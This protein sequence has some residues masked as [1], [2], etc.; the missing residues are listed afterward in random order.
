MGRT[1]KLISRIVNA[2]FGSSM[3]KKLGVVLYVESEGEH[4]KTR[5]ITNED[6]FR[7]IEEFHKFGT[8]T[9]HDVDSPEIGAMMVVEPLEIMFYTF[10]GRYIKLLGSVEYEESEAVPDVM[11]EIDFEAR[12][13][14]RRKEENDSWRFYQ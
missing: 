3:S 10:D 13:D 4:Y 14:Q 11:P 1:R 5:I 9:V 6:K 7:M 12:A 2:R 8:I